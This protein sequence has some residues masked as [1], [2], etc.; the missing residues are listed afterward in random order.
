V[1]VYPNPAGN[2]LNVSL[3]ATLTNATA[4]ANITD[5]LGR[6]LLTFNLNSDVPNRLDISKLPDGIYMLKVIS[7]ATSAPDMQKIIIRR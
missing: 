2:T 5:C 7:A 4:A 3:P 1:F 6:E